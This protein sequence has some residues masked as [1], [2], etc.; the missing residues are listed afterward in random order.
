MIKVDRGQTGSPRKKPLHPGYDLP[1]P[2]LPQE[3]GRGS[4]I[5][6]CRRVPWS[7]GDHLSSIDTRTPEC[8][9]DTLPPHTPSCLSDAVYNTEY[10]NCCF[11]GKVATYRSIPLALGEQTAHKETHSI[12]T[13]GHAGYPLAQ[14]HP[15]Y[16]MLG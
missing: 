12:N 3:G 16:A 9:W 6:G 1:F 8:A 11:C 2:L 15:L 10:S 14:V 13:H 4:C 5:L 7:R